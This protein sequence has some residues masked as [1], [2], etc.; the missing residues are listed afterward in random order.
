MQI[1][2][3]P[4]EEKQRLYYSLKTFLYVSEN[5]GIPG[6]P[7]PIHPAEAL[8][9]NLELIDVVPGFLFA[10]TWKAFLCL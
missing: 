8:V 1:K 5:V 10:V 7:K 9:S 6:R 2:K 4:I 3:T